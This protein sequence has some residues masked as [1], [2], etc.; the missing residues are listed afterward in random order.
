MYFSIPINCEGGEMGILV[1][2]FQKKDTL[3]IVPKVVYI[4]G[5]QI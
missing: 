5:M 3:F 4:N 2:F 1:N